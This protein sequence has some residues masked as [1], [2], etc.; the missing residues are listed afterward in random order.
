[1]KSALKLMVPDAFLEWH[2]DQQDRWEFV[3][4]MPRMMTACDARP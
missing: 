3:D 4:G 2:L 1:M